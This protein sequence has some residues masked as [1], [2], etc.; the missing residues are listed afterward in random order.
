[1]SDSPFKGPFRYDPAVSAIFDVGNHRVLDVRGWG[2]LTGKGVGALGMADDEAEDA[3]KAIGQHVCDLLNAPPSIPPPQFR[4]MVQEAFREGC[5]GCGVPPPARCGE[6]V[7]CT[8]CPVWLNSKA[9][10]ALDKMEKS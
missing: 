8:L 10:A 6:M 2:Y 7:S 1:M 4:E 5:D 3:Q 9:K